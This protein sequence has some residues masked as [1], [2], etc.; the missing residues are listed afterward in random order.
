MSCPAYEGMRDSLHR[1]PDSKL[2]FIVYRCTYDSD[3][4]W[5]KCMSYLTTYVRTRLEKDKLGD[6]ADRPDWNIQQDRAALDGANLET[7]RRH[8]TDI[9]IG[10]E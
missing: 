5:E 2:G 10:V 3:A 7:V 8:V 6:I 1:Y 4:D 9:S